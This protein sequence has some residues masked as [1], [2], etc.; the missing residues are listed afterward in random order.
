ME[1]Q[2]CLDSLLSPL[3]LEIAPG[4]GDLSVWPPITPWPR[5]QELEEVLVQKAHHI[6]QSREAGSW[7]VT[8]PR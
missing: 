7:Q 2:S 3:D 6:A 8:Y 4:D 5:T 1:P